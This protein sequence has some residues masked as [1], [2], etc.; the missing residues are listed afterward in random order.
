MCGS[1]AECMRLSS[2]QSS[3]CNLS[4]LLMFAISD[5]QPTMDL[6]HTT[7]PTPI[8]RP[9]QYRCCRWRQTAARQ[10]TSLIATKTFQ[11]SKQVTWL[12]HIH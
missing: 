12:Q 3:I 7:W 6:S 11:L 5:F 2:S 9:P 1:R 10:R 8:V 4:R